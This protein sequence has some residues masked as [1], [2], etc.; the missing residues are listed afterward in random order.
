MVL[1]YHVSE[2]VSVCWL[3]V[4]RE[5]DLQTFFKFDQICKQYNI[6]NFHYKSKV[7]GISRL[8]NNNKKVNDQ[9]KEQVSHFNNLG[10]H[11]GYDKNVAID[12]E[13]TKFKMICGTISL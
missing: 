2:C 1:R 12:V 4:T 5:S 7:N 3:L 8:G 11:I 13:L 10:N 9:I 6:E